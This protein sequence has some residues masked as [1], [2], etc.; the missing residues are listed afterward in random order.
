MYG[1]DIDLSYR[2]LKS[3]YKNY[4]FPET[5]IIHYKGEST[6]KSSVNYVFVFYR[7]MVIF[8]KKHFSKSNAS[9]FSFFINLAIYLRAGTAILQQFII[10]SFLPLCDALLLFASMYFLKTYWG[11]NMKVNYP[12]EFMFFAV[13]GYILVW[14]LAVFFSG[15][16]DRP[17]S[18]QKIVRGIISG[19]LLILVIYALLPETYRFS[20]ALILL[21]SVWAIVSMVA[22]RLVIHLFFRKS[23]PLAGEAR[24]KLLIVGEEEEGSRVLSL[25][26]LSDTT[27]NFIGFVKPENHEQKNLTRAFPEYAQYLLGNISQLSE[28][29]EV[30]SIDELIFCGKD[31]SSNEII[32]G[33]SMAGGRSI[34]FKIAPPESLFIIG[35]SSVENPGKLYVIDINSIGSPVNK[36]N[37]RF[38]DLFTSFILL[39]LF[40]V[41]IF[42]QRKPGNFLGNLSRVIRGKRSWV[43]YIPGNKL[44]GGLPSIREAVLNPLDALRHSPADEAT[45][46]RLNSLYAKDYRVYTDLNIM[47]KGWRNLGKR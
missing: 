28:M 1:E 19:T 22:F 39:L 40:P 15:G 42:V 46:H 33:M 45:L 36:R 23:M 38:I 32:R 21:G 29:V 9:L 10:R 34:E 31:V 14:L 25:L 16:Y 13:P 4:Y 26:K 6:R 11:T 18:I 3:G 27:H 47:L 2:L 17:L 44:T 7:A 20:R 43:G 12:P 5:R 41:M 35:S 24:K 37:K 30:Y 8:A